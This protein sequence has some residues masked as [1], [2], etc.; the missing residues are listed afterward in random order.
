[1]RWTFYLYA[2]TGLPWALCLAFYGLRS[3]WWRS[4]TGRALFWTYGALTAVLALAALLRVLDLPYRQAVV[5]A[6]VALAGVFIAGL[7]QLINVIRLQR[8]DQRS[9]SPARRS[10]D[11]H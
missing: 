10:T 5:L 11:P 3:P 4:W 8:R 9:E 6:V 2:V 1:V 7:A